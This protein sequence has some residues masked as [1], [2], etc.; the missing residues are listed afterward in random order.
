MQ[1]SCTHIKQVLP[2][3]YFIVSFKGAVSS[4]TDLGVIEYIVRRHGLIRV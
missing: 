2:C 1:A 3:L 4:Q